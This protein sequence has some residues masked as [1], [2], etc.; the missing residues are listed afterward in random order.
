MID[1]EKL[2]SFLPVYAYE[3]ETEGETVTTTD[4]WY[5]HQHPK[6][7]QPPAGWTRIERDEEFT[8][9]QIAALKAYEESFWFPPTVVP[10]EED[11][12]I[13][14]LNGKVTSAYFRMPYGE[15]LSGWIKNGNGISPTC[16]RHFPKL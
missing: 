9:D 8:N 7:T 3:Y 12:Y 5:P 4:Y 2:N 15:W 14:E 13:V 1:V 11:N 6:G 10:T 16:W